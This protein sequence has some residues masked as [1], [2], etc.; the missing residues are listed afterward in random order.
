MQRFRAN[1]YEIVAGE[2]EIIFLDRKTWGIGWAMAVLGILAVVPILMTV[3]GP[4]AVAGLPTA[5]AE[6]GFP[7][8]IAVLAL[9]IWLLGRTYRRRRSEPAE[10]IRD[11]LILDLRSDALRSRM[12]EILAQTDELKARMHIDWWTRGTM[13]LVV[14]H[15]PGGRRTIYRTL[16][17]RRSLDVLAFLREQGIDAV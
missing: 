13:R 4:G 14:L 16:G 2:H 1:G 8:A 10:E 7:A 5:V 3:A 17:R 11:L 6:W 15:W 12:G 9:A